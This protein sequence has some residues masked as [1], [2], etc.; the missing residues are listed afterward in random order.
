MS[1]QD[2]ILIVLTIIMFLGYFIISPLLRYKGMQKN[3]E[4][5]SKFLNDLKL[6]DKIVLN[7]GVFGKLLEKKDESY[8]IEISKGV[9]IEVLS[10]SIIGRR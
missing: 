10:S 3:N 2:I 7:S 6:G 9:I 1:T 4:K 8:S 5:H